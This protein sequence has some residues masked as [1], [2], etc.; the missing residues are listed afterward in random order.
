MERIECAD[1]VSN[2]A[3]IADK[4]NKT[5]LNVILKR[6]GSWIEHVIRGKGML[7]TALEDTMECERNKE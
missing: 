3:L 5:I 2:D 4:E 6:N 7:T 1:A